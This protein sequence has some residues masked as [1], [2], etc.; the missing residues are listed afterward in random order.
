MVG[1][2]ER[3]EWYPDRS[4][5]SLSLSCT[6]S[7]PYNTQM[8][9]AQSFTTRSILKYLLVI[10]LFA[11]NALAQ[12]TPPPTAAGNGSQSVTASAAS[13]VAQP[14]AETPAEAIKRCWQLLTDSVQGAKHIETR[15]QALNALSSLGW[16]MRADELI[17]AA[18]KDPNLDVRTAAILALIS[19]AGK[20]R[21]KPIGSWDGSPGSQE[22]VYT[23]KHR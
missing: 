9:T 14:V 7:R 1:L 6:V 16:S 15:T 12:E 17:A 10:S 19:P 11:G 13:T 23:R 18:M 22:I 8:V 3:S 20:G 4:C 5:A 21:S 2:P